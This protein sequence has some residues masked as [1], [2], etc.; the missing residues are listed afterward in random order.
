MAKMSALGGSAGPEVA[1]KM[2]R[3]DIGKLGEEN[4]WAAHAEALE[5]PAV[6]SWK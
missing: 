6:S 3:E 5:R 4:N 2:R 1:E